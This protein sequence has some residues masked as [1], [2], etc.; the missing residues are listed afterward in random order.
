MEIRKILERDGKKREYIFFTVKYNHHR[1][2][3]TSTVHEVRDREEFRE[4]ECVLCLPRR[5]R[6]WV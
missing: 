2:V 1:D 5:P 4:C 3:E 6:R